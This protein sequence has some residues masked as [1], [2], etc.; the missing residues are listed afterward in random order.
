MVIFN[1]DVK[2]PEGRWNDHHFHE[3]P[4]S[5]AG[6]MAKMPAGGPPMEGGYGT[7]ETD[8]K[9]FPFD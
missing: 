1:S 5:L 3:F 7:P 4:A 9:K 8:P 6:K 2:L